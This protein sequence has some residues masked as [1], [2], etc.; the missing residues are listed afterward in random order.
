MFSGRG[1]IRVLKI[2]TFSNLYIVDISI[3]KI[4]PVCLID[5]KPSVPHPIDRSVQLQIHLLQI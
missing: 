5:F 2:R 3:V 1:Q 4:R